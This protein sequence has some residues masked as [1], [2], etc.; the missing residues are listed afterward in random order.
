[1]YK[2]NSGS[3]HTLNRS[4]IQTIKKSSKHNSI[5]SHNSS[6]EFIDAKKTVSGQSSGFIVER[7][8]ES[9]YSLSKD[10]GQSN[11]STQKSLLSAYKK[12]EKTLEPEE[13]AK[14][15]DSKSFESVS[16][17]EESEKNR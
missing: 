12:P 5:K 17:S 8:D 9:G 13:E 2:S 6:Q 1:M 3:Q 16:I 15:K 14:E 7:V 4:S 10:D 11:G